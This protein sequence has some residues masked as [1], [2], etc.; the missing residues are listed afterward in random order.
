MSEE[1]RTERWLY[2]G[3][4]ESVKKEGRLLQTFLVLPEDLGG[5][6]PPPVHHLDISDRR[7][8]DKLI[9]GASPGSIW[10][11]TA[12]GDS[13]YNRGQKAPRMVGFWEDRDY[14]R[15]LQARDSAVYSAAQRVKNIRSEL[16]EDDLRSILAPIGRAYRSLSTIQRTAFL[17]Q[18][19]RIVCEWRD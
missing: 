6:S 16:A 11:V 1:Q 10:E 13:V 17:V 4:E 3:R 5:F 12:E 14:R 19:T 8:F 18:I 2:L 7:V 9:S 15:Q